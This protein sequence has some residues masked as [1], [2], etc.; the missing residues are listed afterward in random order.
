[1]DIMLALQQAS[2]SFSTLISGVKYD[3]NMC[4]NVNN[5]RP[6]PAAQRSG[7]LPDKDGLNG[8]GGVRDGPGTE[9]PSVTLFR[10]YLRLRTVHPEPD[11]GT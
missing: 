6:G 10:E 11:Y 9:D 3:L 7:M 4:V 1:M 5:K 8:G 2:F